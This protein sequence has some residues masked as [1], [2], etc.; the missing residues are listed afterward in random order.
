MKF[1]LF[2]RVF[3]SSNKKRQEVDVVLAN[4]VVGPQGC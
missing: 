1:A 3:M 2:C 4:I